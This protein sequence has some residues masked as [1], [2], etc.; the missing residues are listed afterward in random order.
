MTAGNKKALACIASLLILLVSCGEAASPAGETPVTAAVTAAE[1]AVLPILTVPVPLLLMIAAPLVVEDDGQLTE[2]VSY[3]FLRA[4]A[5]AFRPG[6]V[7]IGKSVYGR[8]VEVA[9]CRN[10]DGTIAAVLLNRAGET[11]RVNLRMGGKIVQNV[12]L[13]AGALTTVEI[14]A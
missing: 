9:A 10:A 4:I 7:R 14:G 12:E 3:A 8:D 5:R 6:A 1:T 11:V 13:P 2:T